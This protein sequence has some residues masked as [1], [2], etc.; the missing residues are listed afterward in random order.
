[1]NAITTYRPG[2]LG[3][4]VINEVF[5]SF[6]DFLP[7]SHPHRVILLPTFIETMMAPQ[8]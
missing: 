4:K 6:N 7:I 1:M 3:H 2:L 8:C 5:D